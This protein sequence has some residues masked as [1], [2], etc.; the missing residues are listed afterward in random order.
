MGQCERAYSHSGRAK[1]GAS[2]KRRKKRGGGGERREP[3]LF[4]SRPISRAA[5][6]ANKLFRAVRFITARTGTLAMQAKMTCTVQICKIISFP[7]T[8]CYTSVSDTL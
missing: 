6:K 2:A 5:R 3:H 7:L 8:L 1:N 4:C